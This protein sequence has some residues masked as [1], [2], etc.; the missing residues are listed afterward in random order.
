MTQ[1]FL[2]Q[3]LNTTSLKEVLFKLTKLKLQFPNVHSKKILLA[4]VE[5]E[6]S[7][8]SK[9]QFSYS[10]VGNIFS[11]KSFFEIVKFEY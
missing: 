3:F 11:V 6:K 8:P 2:L 10:L 9:W 5:L 1:E 7:H 4:N